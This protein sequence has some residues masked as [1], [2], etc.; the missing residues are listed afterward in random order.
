[1]EQDNKEQL[2][3]IVSEI[4]DKMG[5]TVEVEVKEMPKN[6]IFMKDSNDIELPES[7]I[8][9]VLSDEN[10]SFLIGQQGNNLQALQHIVRLVLKNRMKEKINCLV[11]VNAYRI[12]RAGYIKNIAE[13]AA[14]EALSEKRS[15]IMKPMSSFERR[16]VHMV[17]SANEAVATESIGEGENRKVV[18]RPVEMV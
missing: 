1:M 9:N 4:I 16:I 12:E 13:E 3:N 11:D 17:L 5:F 6:S 14:Q 15:I 8:C 7:F 2:K 18:V 10:S